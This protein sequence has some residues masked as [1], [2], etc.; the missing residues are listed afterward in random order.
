MKT[1]KEDLKMKK[2]NPYPPDIFTEP[3]NWKD[4]TNYLK[5]GG[6]SPDAIFGSWGRKVWL[7]AVKDMQEIIK[8][9]PKEKGSKITIQKGGIEWKIKN[10]WKI[11]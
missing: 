5:K 9:T 1:I 6:F 3:E 2:Y 4:I 7:N 10:N 11:K 8:A